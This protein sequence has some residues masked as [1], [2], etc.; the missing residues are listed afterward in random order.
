MSAL[1]GLLTLKN[2][3]TNDLVGE[4]QESVFVRN[5]KGFNVG[6]TLIG[7][8]SRLSAETADNIEFNWWERDP[9]RRNV[10]STNGRTS[11]DV[12]M[13][14]DDSLGNAVWQIL[15]AGHVLKNDRTS[16]YVRV[17]TDPTSNTLLAGTAQDGSG[18]GTAWMLCVMDQD[19]ADDG[20]GFAILRGVCLA[21]GGTTT[22]KGT[23]CG[24]DAQSELI[25]AV[26]TGNSC[27]V[28]LVALAAGA[29]GTVLFDGVACCFGAH[30]VNA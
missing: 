28:S 21:L 8:M 17:I 23:M 19:L 2:A 10:F 13:D 30:A 16:E 14:L 4:F 11:V 27:A 5:A 3:Q 22:A 20:V 15:G 25:A 12:D 1:A 24:P 29:L 18:T 7:L 9:V 6:S 26:A